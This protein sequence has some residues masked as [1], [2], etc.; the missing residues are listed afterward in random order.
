MARILL[1]GATSGIGLAAATQLAS[2]PNELM[3]HGPEPEERADGAIEEVRR[4][5]HP[6][7]RVVYAQAD[8]T[9][10]NG[11]R[12]LANQATTALPTLDVLVNNAA[13]PGPP[14]LRTGSAHTELAYQVNFLAGVMLTHLMLQALAPAGRVVNVA[15][16]THYGADLDLDDLGFRRRRYSS[17]E[18]YAQSKLAIVTYTSWL[19]SHVAQTVVSIHP[20]VVSTALLHAMF[21]TGGIDTSVGGA[22]LVASLTAD[23]ASGTYLDETTPSTPSDQSLDVQIQRALVEDTS[24]RL[25]TTLP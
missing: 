22:N 8:F 21:S 17:S 24:A 16:A 23:V 3:I 15:S 4:A 11:P 2:E 20:G 14:E 12:L 5:A 10:P 18:A 19:A 6:D 1:T 9:D 7:S 25:G 13:I